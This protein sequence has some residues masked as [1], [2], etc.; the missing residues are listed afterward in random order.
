M[1]VR[2]ALLGLLAQEARHG[3]ELHAAFEAIVGGR[4]AWAI[5]PAQ[6]YTTLAR[7]EDTGLIARQ[8]VEQSGGPERLTYA[9]TPAGQAEL[10]H[11]LLTP[12]EAQHQ[13]DEFFLKFMLSIASGVADPYQVVYRQRTGLYRQLH[14]MT[15][16][17]GTLDPRTA[18][19]YVLL[20]DRAIMQLEADLRWLEMIEARLDD[21]RRQPVPEPEARP[22]GRPPKG[23]ERHGDR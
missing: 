3:Y 10:A 20:I 16:K 15:V 18:L 14:A 5:K 1:S 23:S 11:W 17:R 12:T 6:I 8:G 19:A 9:I 2:N 21:I 7:L 13:R 22:R 4:E